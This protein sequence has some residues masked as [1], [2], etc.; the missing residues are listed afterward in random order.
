MDVS[1]TTHRRFVQMFGDVVLGVEHGA[2]E[3][4]LEAKKEAK[5]V[6]LDTEL[7]ANDLVELVSEF[8]SVVKKETGADFPDE[9]RQRKKEGH[10]HHGHDCQLPGQDQHGNQG[11]QEDNGVRK[12]VGQGAGHHRLNPADIVGDT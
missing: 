7:D 8:K 9:P 6:E 10:G 4:L 3:H 12:G 11:A 2:F 5:G 1:L